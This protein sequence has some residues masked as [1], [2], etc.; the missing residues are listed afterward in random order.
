MLSSNKSTSAVI[1]RPFQFNATTVVLG[2]G[3]EFI[4]EQRSQCPDKTSY[5]IYRTKNH[6]EAH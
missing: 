5:R 4:V 3:S 1:A 6:N 2:I